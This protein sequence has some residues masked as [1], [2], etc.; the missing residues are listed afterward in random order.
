MLKTRIKK[1]FSA[2]API[3]VLMAVTML[4]ACSFGEN[5]YKDIEGYDDVQRAKKLYTELDSGHFYM[6][7][8]STGKVTE[9]FTFRYRED[10]NLTYIYMGTERETIYYEFHN[11]SEINYKTNSDAEWSFTE[12]GNEKYFVYDRENRHPYT[13]EGV[14][15][16][17]AYAV[18]DSKVEKSADGKKITFYYNAELLADQLAELGEIQSF[19]SSVWLD[20]DGYCYR[21]D[22]KGVFEKDGAE[23]VSD[24]SMFIDSMNELGEL[25]RPDV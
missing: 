10:G 9:E 1:I 2:F 25:K 18:T 3:L 21:L 15:S 19:E 8:N 23:E 16:M 6:Q 13:N 12:Q 22:Q 14:I 11:G 24:F 7:D 20:G 4:G 5:S 17:N